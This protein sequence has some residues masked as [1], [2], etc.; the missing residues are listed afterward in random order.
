MSLLWTSPPYQD[1]I[2][3]NPRHH[4]TLCRVTELCNFFLEATFH[5]RHKRI[6]WKAWRTF[7]SGMVT[8]RTA[9]RNR[10]P[11]GAE[12]STVRAVADKSTLPRGNRVPAMWVFQLAYLVLQGRLKRIIVLCC[13]EK[14]GLGSASSWNVFCR[15]ITTFVSPARSAT[16]NWVLQFLQSERAKSSAKV[17]L[18][19]SVCPM[20]LPM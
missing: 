13:Q 16:R 5:T 2:L 18:T 10:D 7:T 11:S 1:R 15:F 19:S 20:M 14:T 17:S 6:W 8:Q 9:W 4:C 3:L 12:A